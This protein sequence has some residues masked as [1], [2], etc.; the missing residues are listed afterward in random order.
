MNIT[1]YSPK[2]LMVRIGKRA[3]ARR[4]ALG[5]RQVDVAR[6]AGIAL[7]TLHRFEAGEN[8]S[9]DV[10]ARVALALRAED[11]LAEL[12]SEPEA[13]SLDDILTAQRRRERAPKRQ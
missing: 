2:D 4:L 3:K 13:R 11:A 12:F 9:I 7:P 1:L 5:L 6:A 8:T 10:I